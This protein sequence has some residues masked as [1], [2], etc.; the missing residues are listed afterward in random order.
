MRAGGVWGV[1]GMGGWYVGRGVG[2]GE[3]RNLGRGDSVGRGLPKGRAEGIARGPMQ[4]GGVRTVR[5]VRRGVSVGRRQK[6][7]VEKMRSC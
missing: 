1:F 5:L 2:R 4:C 7:C 3:G 6:P